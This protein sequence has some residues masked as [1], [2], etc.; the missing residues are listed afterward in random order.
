MRAIA[1]VAG[2]GWILV[3]GSLRLV[4]EIRSIIRELGAEPRRFSFTEKRVDKRRSVEDDGT[5]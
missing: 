1:L 4:G 5:G 2:R 3:T